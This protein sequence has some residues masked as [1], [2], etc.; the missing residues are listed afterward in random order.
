[1]KIKIGISTIVLF[2]ITLSTLDV[3]AQQ[4]RTEGNY[5]VIDCATMPAKA[6]RMAVHT[7]AAPTHNEQ[8]VWNRVAYQKFAVSKTNIG[9]AA[10]TATMNF[11]TAASAC[12]AYAGPNGGE[13]GQWRLPSQRELQLT[14]TMKT[15]LEAQSGFTAFTSGVYWSS[16]E[17]SGDTSRAW[18]VNFS[19]GNMGSLTKV[20]N[21][22][23]RC[24]RDM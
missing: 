5:V 7:D 21:A 8:D 2:V 19:R 23:V 18:L 12:T 13:A 24:V 11:A 4:V 1:M 3:C 22:Y 14:W 10:G 20:G 9:S 16:T 6:R 15:K 17:S